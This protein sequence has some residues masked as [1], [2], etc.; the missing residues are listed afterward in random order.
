[1]ST[2]NNSINAIIAVTGSCVT[3]RTTFARQAAMTPRILAFNEVTDAVMGKDRVWCSYVVAQDNRV[4]DVEDAIA[5]NTQDH[6]IFNG[7]Y[8]GAKNYD[9]EGRFYYDLGGTL[10]EVEAIEDAISTFAVTYDYAA[11]FGSKEYTSLIMLTYLNSQ[12]M[13]HK[14][15][16]DLWVYCP[17]H[18]IIDTNWEQMVATNARDFDHFFLYDEDHEM[19]LNPE[20]N[21]DP[22]YT[23]V[24]DA[25]KVYM[26]E[27]THDNFAALSYAYKGLS[28]KM[29]K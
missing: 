17:Y 16:F 5:I 6:I 15:A 22:L 25:F 11:A 13:D 8:A 7:H 1:M 29:S 21:D 14:K 9:Y 10:H 23:V 18:E 19:W 27:P 4:L 28:G 12:L 24:W 3:N 20:M 26:E 2:I